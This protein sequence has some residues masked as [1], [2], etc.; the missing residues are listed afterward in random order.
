MAL[1][2]P[3]V[4]TNVGALPEIVKH[5]ESGLVVP[6]GKTEKLAMALYEILHDRRRANRMGKTAQRFVRRNFDHKLLIDRLEAVYLKAL[7]T[8]RFKNKDI[9]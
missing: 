2:V 5:G 3:P 9:L 8:R 7:R 6:Y 1:G 4:V